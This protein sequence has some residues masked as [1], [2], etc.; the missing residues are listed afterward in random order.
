MSALEAH[1]SSV[2]VPQ[3]EVHA[4]DGGDHVGDQDAFHHSRHGLQI[5]EA[6]VTQPLLAQRPTSKTPAW[7]WLIYQQ[8][9]RTAGF[10]ADADALWAELNSP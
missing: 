5:A 6:G 8:R 10:S 4:A 9:L 2:G 1:S 7:P 3:N